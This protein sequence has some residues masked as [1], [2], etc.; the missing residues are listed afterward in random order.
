MAR[1]LEFF[2]FSEQQEEEE[3]VRGAKDEPTV[4]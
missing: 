4:Q 2:F 3:S 1:H